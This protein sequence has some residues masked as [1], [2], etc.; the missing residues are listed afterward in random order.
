MKPMGKSNRDKPARQNK[1]LGCFKG[2]IK[3]ADDFD[4]WPED[5]AKDLGMKIQ[6][7]EN[8]AAKNKTAPPT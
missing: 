8:R 1:R 4:E 6:G 2:K 3:I 7:R 5:I